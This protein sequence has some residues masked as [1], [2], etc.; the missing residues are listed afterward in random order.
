MDKEK[1]QSEGIIKEETIGFLKSKLNMQTGTLILTNKRVYLEITK[2]NVTYGGIAGLI[3]SL[4]VKN[5]PKPVFDIENK[6]IQNIAQGKHGLAKNILEITDM[7]NITYR[8]LVKSYPEW[9]ELLKK[10]SGK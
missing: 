5:K 8:I 9:E 7:Q 2:S 6:T 1:L 4:L 3:I 10:A